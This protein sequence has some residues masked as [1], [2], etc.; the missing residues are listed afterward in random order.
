MWNG[1]KTGSRRARAQ[2]QTKLHTDRLVDIRLAMLDM[3]GS[4]GISQY[5]SVARRIH[6]SSDAQSLWYARA[7]LMAALAGL[8]G[9]QVAHTRMISLSVLFDGMLPRGMM[10][11]PTTL[12][13]DQHSTF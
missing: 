3:L 8:H 7:D 12:R 9:E 5:P 11:R 13:P 6:L 10:S 2:K 1:G 4:E